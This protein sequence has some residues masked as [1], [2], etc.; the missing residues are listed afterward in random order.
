MLMLMPSPIRCSIAGRPFRRGRHLH[1]QVLP[2]DVLPEPFGFRDGPLGIHRQIGRDLEADETVVAV[3]AVVNRAQHVGGVLDVLDGDRLEQ[4]GDGAVARLQGVADRAVIFVRTADRLFEDRGVRRHALD[5]VGIDQR[6][7]VALGDEAAGE[8][9]QPDRLAMVFEC[10]DGIHGACSVRSVFLGFRQL[11]GAGPES[12]HLVGR[13]AGWNGAVRDDNAIGTGSIPKM[14]GLAGLDT[15]R[16]GRTGFREWRHQRAHARSREGGR[17][18]PSF[19]APRLPRVF[20][21]PDRAWRD[22]GGSGRHRRAFEGSCAK[23]S[24][25]GC[26]GTQPACRRGS[27]RAGAIAT[28]SE[29][30]KYSAGYERAKVRRPNRANER[31]T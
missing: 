2:L 26:R 30:K 9:V 17:H 21:C 25:G 27:G 22:H 15:S 12:Q 18:E 16:T 6:L 24:A 11:S 10:F 1:H 19:F 4:V 8:E 31:S 20:V 28:E 3:Q 5:A 7:E 14:A 23:H 29:H 13:A